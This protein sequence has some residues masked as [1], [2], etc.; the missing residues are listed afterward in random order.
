VA[1]GYQDTFND[2][3]LVVVMIETIDGIINADEIAATFGIDVVIQGNNDLS[4][5]SGFRDHRAH[6]P[7][8]TQLRG[9][10]GHVKQG[11]QEV[12]HAR[13]SVGQT[14]GATQRCRNPDSGGEWRIRDPHAEGARLPHVET[15]KF[16]VRSFPDSNARATAG[17]V[18]R[19]GVHAAVRVVSDGA[20]WACAFALFS[21]AR[22][23]F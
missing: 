5:F 10:D 1:G 7:R 22:R 3:M 8:A 18:G 17:V 11:G 9:H 19:S 15:E 2:N 14:S 4:R 12:R 21:A 23:C 6:A 13:A 20:R 16:D